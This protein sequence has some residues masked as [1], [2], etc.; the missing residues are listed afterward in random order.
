MRKIILLFLLLTIPLLSKADSIS[1]KLWVT[2]YELPA[3]FYDTATDS[4]VMA[5][6]LYYKVYCPKVVLAQ[7]KLESGNFKSD[8]FLNSNNLF[9]LKDSKGRYRKFKYWTQSVKLYT[10][11][12]QRRYK[13]PEN[14]FRFLWRIRY[15]K[16]PRYIKKLKKIL[17]DD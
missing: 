5:C 9:G 2:D 16:D 7:G 8:Y 3:F 10:N 12:I 4:T 13:P 15:A 11:V 17:N 1:S 6:L 14:Y